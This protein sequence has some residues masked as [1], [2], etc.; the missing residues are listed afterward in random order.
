MNL[1]VTK[2]KDKDCEIC[3]HMSKHD[4]ATF[5]S[6]DGV[7]FNELELDDLGSMEMTPSIQAVAAALEQHA[8]NPDYTLD[9]P[10]YVILDDNLK[11]VTH[12]TGAMTVKDIRNAVDGVKL[13]SM[14]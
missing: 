10:T 1:S 7:V 14:I 13:P 9:L 12:L 11:Y 4:R 5:E 6:F 2:V 8:L 3:L